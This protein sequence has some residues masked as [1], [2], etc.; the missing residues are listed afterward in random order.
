MSEVAITLVYRYLPLF[1]ALHNRRYQILAVCWQ[2]RA[3]AQRL[4]ANAANGY[5]RVRMAGLCYDTQHLFSLEAFLQGKSP[6]EPLFGL[7]SG[8][9]DSIAENL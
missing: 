7:G 3:V 4:G 1:H 6:V 9:G 5:L 8:M 2:R